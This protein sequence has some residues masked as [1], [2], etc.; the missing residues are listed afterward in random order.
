MRGE[1]DNDP[2]SEFIGNINRP[3]YSL[4]IRGGRNCL[5][6]CLL[7]VANVFVG[8]D[9]GVRWDC[10]VISLYG[11][12]QQVLCIFNLKVVRFLTPVL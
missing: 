3:S 1:G 5:Q 4:I 11:A 2:V 9:D 7:V 6:K 8:T 12:Q 10:F